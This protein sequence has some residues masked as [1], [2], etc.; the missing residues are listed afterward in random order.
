[1]FAYC[2][3]ATAGL[4]GLAAVGIFTGGLESSYISRHDMVTQ[5][6][7]AL[8]K[9]YGLRDRRAR[10][11]DSGCT[12]WSPRPDEAFEARFRSCAEKYEPATM[13]V[14]DSHARAFWS[15]TALRCAASSSTCPVLI[16]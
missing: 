11:I 8:I 15:A 13:V 16:S 5:R 10:L 14:G 4:A 7:Y 12:F 3:V 6:A 2:G 9:Q 1:V